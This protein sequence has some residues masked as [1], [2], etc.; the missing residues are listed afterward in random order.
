VICPVAA[1]ALVAAIMAKIAAPAETAV[2]RI[3]LLTNRLP[4]ESRCL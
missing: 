3:D 2:P 4:S 1:D